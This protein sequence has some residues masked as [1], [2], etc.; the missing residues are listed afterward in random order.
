MFAVVPMVQLIP[1]QQL[2]SFTIGAPQRN[3]S[4]NM[5]E[6][7][8]VTVLHLRFRADEENDGRKASCFQDR[9]RLETRR[10]TDGQDKTE[11]VFRTHAPSAK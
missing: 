11:R 2:C 10:Q 5:N 1:E 6:L 3:R 9:V 8:F 7:V 4:V